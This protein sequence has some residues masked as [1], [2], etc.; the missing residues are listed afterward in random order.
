MGFEIKTEHFN[1]PFDLLLEL[2]E[3]RKLFINEI[4]LSKVTDDFIAYIESKQSGPDGE[5]PM[6]E[7]ASF[8]L[9]AATLILIKSKSLL[10][11]LELS[12]E[13]QGDIKSL[14]NRLAIYKRIREASATVQKHFG[15]TPLFA[16]QHRN[17]LETVFSPGRE[18]SLTRDTLF[19]A[20]QKVIAQIPKVEKLPEVVVKKVVSLEVMIENLTKRVQQSL[21]MSFRDFSAGNK[22]EKINVIVSFL[23][24][25]ELVKR[26]II[27]A[28]QRGTFDDI[29]METGGNVGVPTY[30]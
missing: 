21:K 28:E 3:R 19:G 12:N 2:I 30:N 22:G 18:G 8:I 16:P 6:G 4:S 24:M 1:G 29:E 7:S 17:F 20:I 26:G 10:P 11:T 9:V 25:L 13:E 27:R 15:E 23:A 5:F 14:E